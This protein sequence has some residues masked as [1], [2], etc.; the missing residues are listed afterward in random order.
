MSGFVL[1][2]KTVRLNAVISQGGF[3]TLCDQVLGRNIVSGANAGTLWKERKHMKRIFC[4]YWGTRVLEK[5]SWERSM[6]DHK[7]VCL[8]IKMF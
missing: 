3:G 4:F 7:V 5:A 1:I 8:S 2:D 6:L